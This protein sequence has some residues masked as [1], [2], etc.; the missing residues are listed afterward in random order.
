[1]NGYETFCKI[2]RLADQKHLSAAQI[3]A[4]LDLDLKTAEKWIQ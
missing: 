3:A 2:R 1:M 4:E